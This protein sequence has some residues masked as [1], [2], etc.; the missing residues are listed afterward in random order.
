MKNDSICEG[1]G[2]GLVVVY[3]GSPVRWVSARAMLWW[4]FRIDLAGDCDYSLNAA[5]SKVYA[6]RSWR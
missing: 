4:L 2:V 1:D 5:A 6:E 3:D